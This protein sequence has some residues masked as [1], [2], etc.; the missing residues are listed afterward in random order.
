MHCA[1]EQALSMG[2]IIFCLIYGILANNNVQYIV[3][4]NQ[5]RYI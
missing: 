4:F 2:Y 1:A 5:R 3:D